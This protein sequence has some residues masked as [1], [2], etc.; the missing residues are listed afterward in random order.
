GNLWALTLP[1]LK[2]HYHP[3]CLAEYTEN[4]KT[5]IRMGLCA[6]FLFLRQHERFLE[7]SR[8]SAKTP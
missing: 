2:N 3:T 4:I 1:F 7:I 6:M 5:E 8:C